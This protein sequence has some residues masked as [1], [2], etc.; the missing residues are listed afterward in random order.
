MN[1]K[2]YSNWFGTNGFHT[3][4]SY[5]EDDY[6]ILDNRKAF[7]SSNNF[8]SNALVIPKQVHSKNVCNATEPGYL[9]E[10]DGVISS[11][12][13]IVLTIQVADC[14]PIFLFDIKNENWGLVHSGWQGTAKNI[15]RESIFKLREAGSDPQNIKALIGPSINQCCFEVGPEVSV[16]FD[17]IFSINGKG[18]RKMV[19]LKSILKHQLIHEGISTGN[20]M[21]DDD[22]TF[23][24]ADLYFSYRRDGDKAGRMV[25]IAGWQ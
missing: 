4:F 3:I 25:A 17:S 13:K 18:D 21:I 5:N 1:H 23:C 2:D 22:C 8:D 9:E 14:S 6:A 10:T 15:A 16:Q 11:D 24:R 19:D 7:A 20:I 12:K